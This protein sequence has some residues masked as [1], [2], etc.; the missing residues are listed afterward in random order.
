M[1]RSRGRGIDFVHHFEG[2]KTLDGLLELVV[3]DVASEPGA[4]PTLNAPARAMAPPA[5]HGNAAR[6]GSP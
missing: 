2:A 4:L 5:G 6:K 1:S 3:R